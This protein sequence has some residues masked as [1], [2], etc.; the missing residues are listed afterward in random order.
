[1]SFKKS[2]TFL[3]L[4]CGVIVVL[5]FLFLNGDPTSILINEDYK[6]KDSIDLSTG[7]VVTRISD[8]EDVGY[9]NNN[10]NNNYGGD[11]ADHR[12]NQNNSED[13]QQIPNSDIDLAALGV[14]EEVEEEEVD[15]IAP[16]PDNVE[17]S[18]TYIQRNNGVSSNNGVINFDAKVL[19]S[20]NIIEITN[21]YRS[22][23]GLHQLKHNAT[24]SKSAAQKVDLIFEEQYFEHTGKNGTT[25]KDLIEGVGYEMIRI[26][27]NLAYGNY[28]READVVNSWINSPGHHAL[29]ISKDFIEIGVS[30]KKGVF[31]GKT[32]WVAVQHFGRPLSLCKELLPSQILRDRIDRNRSRVNNLSNTAEEKNNLIKSFSVPSGNEYYH[33]VSDYNAIVEEHNKLLAII[34]NDIAV[35]NQEIA[36]Y[37]ECTASVK[38]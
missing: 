28:S 37:N 27:E 5:A 9:G 17:Y 7:T 18:P 26:G 21:Q 6:E 11:V 1:M 20:Q 13:A 38:E 36:E 10:N 14:P 12:D 30:I 15:N 31:N 2:I 24:L 22:S 34:K 19:T 8:E 25:M 23:R 16:P 35:Y 29:L 4:F 32:V 33:L 3:L